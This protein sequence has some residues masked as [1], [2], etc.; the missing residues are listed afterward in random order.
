MGRILG[1]LLLYTGVA[2]SRTEP[3]GETLDLRPHRVGHRE[4][5]CDQEGKV[6]A[7]SAPTPQQGAQTS[8]ATSGE[9]RTQRRCR[10]RGTKEPSSFHRRLARTEHR[11]GGRAARQ[12]TCMFPPAVFWVHM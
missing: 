1:L 9:I 8:E 11:K 7:D 5:I 2:I 3:E 10:H 4:K 6:S 12:V